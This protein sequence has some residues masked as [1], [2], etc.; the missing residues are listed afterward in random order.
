MATTIISTQTQYSFGAMTHQ[1]ISRLVSAN[2]SMERLSE[3]I[4]T[5][6][7]GYNGTP[8]TQFEIDASSYT[9]QV[10]PNLFGVV[11]SSEEP[12]KKGQDYSYAV[13]QLNQAWKNFWETARPYVEQLDNGQGVI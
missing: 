12:G 13:L 3:G 10:P 1:L 11:A 6:S 9:S 4:A 5:A 7:S 2:T 8:G